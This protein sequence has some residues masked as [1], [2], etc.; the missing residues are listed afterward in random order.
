MIVDFEAIGGG[1]LITKLGLICVLVAMTNLCHADALVKA[2]L[3]KTMPV[4]P[5]GKPPANLLLH[6]NLLTAPEDERFALTVLQGLVNR[7]QPR[8]YITQDPGWHG[9]AA[10]PKWVEGLR[11]K[12]YVFED[13][14]RPLSL[15][16][17]HRQ[18]FKGVVLYED[19]L[20]QDLAALHKLNA[21][22]LYCALNDAI[23]VS[24]RLNATLKLPVVLDARGKYSTAAEAYGWAY[25]ELWPKANHSVIAFTCPTH[26]VLRDYLVA[27]K[28]LPFWI[29]KEMRKSDDEA[30]WRFVDEA[31][32]NTPLL[33]CW[34]GYGEIPAGRV[35][36]PELQRLTSERGKYIVVT[37]GCFNLTVHSGLAFVRPPTR[38]PQPPPALD[39]SKVYVCLNVTSSVHSAAF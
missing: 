6:L 4:L 35:S 28:I 5:Q 29:S 12:G 15:I 1:H 18:V 23:P 20:R 39:R 27:H 32:A 13:L 22:T 9:P 36:E 38:K 30:C 21:L 33:G 19:N 3:G 10:I 16:D 25:K 8:V 14:E 2:R 17:K 7:E 31:E 24:E 11:Q 37:D 26:I 34:G